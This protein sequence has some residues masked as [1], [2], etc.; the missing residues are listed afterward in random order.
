MHRAKPDKWGS[1]ASARRSVAR[2]IAGASANGDN[3][4]EVAG[5]LG[6]PSDHFGVAE[7]DEEE[8]ELFA[9]LTA[10]LL[11]VVRHENRRER[12]RVA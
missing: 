6:L 10:S 9:S 1:P 8:A 7:E 11:A 12:E 2:W 5:A 3:R 4:S